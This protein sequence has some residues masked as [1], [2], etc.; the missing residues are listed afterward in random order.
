VLSLE[1]YQVFSAPSAA[2]GFELLAS[3]YIAV[4]I[5]DL[6]MPVMNGNEF[7]ERVKQI[8][9]DAVRILLTGDPDL[10]AVT[11]AINRGTLYKFLTK[12]WNDRE[13]LAIVAEACQEHDKQQGT[14]FSFA[15]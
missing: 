8:Y 15:E 12:P 3:R 7:L 1:G 6:R 2:E 10:Q 14:G 5:S 9:P 11:D 4:V 13:L